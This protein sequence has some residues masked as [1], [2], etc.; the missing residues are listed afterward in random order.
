MCAAWNRLPQKAAHNSLKNS[1]AALKQQ[2][3]FLQTQADINNTVLFYPFLNINFQALL[4]LNLPKPWIFQRTFPVQNGGNSMKTVYNAGLLKQKRFCCFT[5]LLFLH[6]EWVF[7]RFNNSFSSQEQSTRLNTVETSNMLQ[8]MVVKCHDKVFIPIFTTFVV[9][10]QHSP[11]QKR[12]LCLFTYLASR[13]VHLE[14]H[15]V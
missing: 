15:I 9:V 5:L 7:S 1:L 4:T 10:R 14:M 13:T 3:N 2:D 11:R 6:A 8:Y 12:Y